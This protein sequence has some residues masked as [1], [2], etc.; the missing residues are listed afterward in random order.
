MSPAVMASQVASGIGMIAGAWM[1]KS[2][3]EEADNNKSMMGGGVV[4]MPRCLPL[5]LC[6]LCNML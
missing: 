3:M 2:L 4:P 5:L 1:F 6:I